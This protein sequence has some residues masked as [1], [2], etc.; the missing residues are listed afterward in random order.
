MFIIEPSA[1]FLT[2]FPQLNQE[3]KKLATAYAEQK[4]V[5]D[6]KLQTV[7]SSLYASLK[8]GDSL[9]QSKRQQGQQPLDI[10]IKSDQPEI[11]GLPWETLY[12][13]DY[14]FLARETGFTLSR[15]IAS[16]SA[17]LPKTEPGPLR[18]LL[19]TSLPDSLD[20]QGRLRVE[21]EQANVQE[22][23]AM[24]EQQGLVQINMPDDGRFD[25]FKTA[26]TSFKP[27]LVY[28]SGHGNFYYQPHKN[29][30]YGSFLFENATGGELSVK[31][32]ELAKCFENTKVQA[33]VLSACQTGKQTS[34]NLSNG[35][36]QCLAHQGIPYII[37]MRESILDVAGI[38][39][40][41][42]FF[43]A[44]AEQ[45]P[46]AA[47]LQAARAAIIQPLAERTFRD[48][49]SPINTSVSYGQWCL[50]MLICPNEQHEMI[51]WQFTPKPRTAA[52]VFNQTLG[53]ISLPER[54]LG[55]RRE[56][57]KFQNE[58]LAGQRKQLLLI[59]AGG[60]GK[61]ALAGKL[62]RTLEKDGY[63]VFAYSAHPEHQWDDDFIFALE[64]ALNKT[65]VEH[66]NQKLPDCTDD[67]SHAL[68]LLGLLM[69][70]QQ[71]KLLVFFDN[72]ESVQDPESRAL[73]DTTLQS[74]LQAAR[75]LTVQGLVLLLTS[76]WQLPDW[77]VNDCYPLGKP[78]YGDFIAFVRE[79]NLPLDFIRLRRTYHS[80]GGNFRA[81][82]FF[83]HALTGIT[84]LKE[85]EFLK[86]LAQAK[87][88][89]QT[90]MA[91]AEL[92]NRLSPHAHNVLN[93]LLA[94]H[95][96]IP[97][98]GIK[99]LI[100][101]ATFCREALNEL[102]AVSL[103]EQYQN[104]DY[105]CTDYQLSE[106]V[107]DFLDK[108]GSGAGGVEQ[109]LFEKAA[110]YQ[111]WLM[112][113][114]RRTVGQIIITH[115]A[116]YS[117]G[118][119]EIAHDLMLERIVESLMRAGLYRTLLEEWLPQACASAVPTTRAAALGNIGAQYLYL[120]DYDSAIDY[121]Q[122]SLA[123]YEENHVLAGVEITLNTIAQVYQARG[124][125]DTA[126]S[127]LQR[128]LVINSET[129]NLVG[130]G[131]LLN[132]IG[133]IHRAHGDLDSALS[134]FQQSLAIREKNDMN[135]AGETLNNI[136]RIY[137]QR[138]DYD[139]ALS[140][141]QRSLVIREN[142]GDL[143]GKAATLNNISQIFQAQ[144]NYDAAL[145]CLRRS[146]AICE[147]IG[148]LSNQAITLN[149]I[150]QI[151]QAQEDYVGA[152]CYLQRALAIEQ[153]IGNQE[154]LCAILFNIGFFHLNNKQPEKAHQ[155]WF[156]SYRIAKSANYA[157][158][159][160]ALEQLAN[161]LGLPGGL[162]FFERLAQQP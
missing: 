130:R 38:Q 30:A 137:L 19:F 87:E 69:E 81:V 41:R 62:S 145:S 75:Q 16:L 131:V 139:T 1:D 155:A 119:N 6:E 43:T 63:Q 76:R 154:G 29:E 74:W 158:T 28:L 49:Q 46:I 59:G 117:A 79:Q 11:L 9:S 116:L 15:R 90:D 138:Q 56:L 24:M 14:G 4:V 128:S 152:L 108:Q 7:G 160:A 12:H 84:E 34:E 110:Y 122:K 146:L 77:S 93:C 73:T 149:N 21:D 36:S 35:L 20:E 58:L 17:E 129:H 33:V 132:N 70:Q 18:I 127:F 23:L 13:P 47:A 72:L 91:L 71:N 96:A 48:A 141:L 85:R 118:L 153:K 140:Y 44:T 109:G 26:L 27:H 5:T 3:A 40:A 83:A 54:F 39:F 8:L 124:N 151:L 143:L 144:Q 2:Q 126:L 115:K 64:M 80:L 148:N 97:F 100:L 61:T 162:L 68:L 150:S 67:E 102:I 53:N 111:V 95:T 113:C 45:Q 125:L 99:K 112:N 104:L 133:E 101:P 136:S 157:E 66:Y 32:Q 121:S 161:W 10:V 135:G 98:D 92:L 60:M 134:F 51:D 22:A 25:S 55:R 120:G 88:E 106:L 142:I 42:A 57:R 94:Y 159:L 107:R 103:V 147:K 50:P 156:E 37:G 123:I 86:K 105:L 78:V 31:E 65:Q 82:M 114:E 89:S 52:D